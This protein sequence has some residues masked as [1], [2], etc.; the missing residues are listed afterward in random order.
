VGSGEQLRQADSTGAQVGAKTVRL[1]Q[2]VDVHPPHFHRHRCVPD[3]CVSILLHLICQ[4]TSSNSCTLNLPFACCL[5]SP[6]HR[7]REQTACV[8]LTQVHIDPFRAGAGV[9][10]RGLVADQQQHA[11]GASASRVLYPVD[12]REFGVDATAKHLSGA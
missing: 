4:H 7:P 11:A 1:L 3:Q 10:E 12:G 6:S 9:A 5:G 2:L 8:L